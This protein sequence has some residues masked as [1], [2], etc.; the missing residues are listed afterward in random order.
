MS[1]GIYVHGR[2]RD[3]TQMISDADIEA[4]ARCDVQRPA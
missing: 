3:A 2:L 4:L 1:D